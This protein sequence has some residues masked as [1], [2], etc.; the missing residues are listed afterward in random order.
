MHWR[1][2]CGVVILGQAKDRQCC[3]IAVNML[4]VGEV[5]VL[6]AIAVA[7]RSACNID[8]THSYFRRSFDPIRRYTLQNVAEGKRSRG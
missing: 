6:F 4:Y 3:H 1:W 8:T 2:E 7:Q 5:Y